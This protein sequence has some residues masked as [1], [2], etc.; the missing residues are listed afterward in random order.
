MQK[1]MIFNVM[2][3]VLAVN[4]C[5]TV[6]AAPQAGPTPPNPMAQVAEAVDRLVDGYGY[7]VFTHDDKKINPFLPNN[8]DISAFASHQELG[9]FLTKEPSANPQLSFKVPKEQVIVSVARGPDFMADSLANM[10]LMNKSK[11]EKI[12]FYAA[13]LPA[14][15]IAS[16]NPCLQQGVVTAGYQE[17][18]PGGDESGC[19]PFIKRE[20]TA[21]YNLNSLLGPTVYKDKEQATMAYDFIQFLTGLNLPYEVLEATEEARKNPNYPK[22]QVALRNY[23]A[24]LGVGTANLYNL[25]AERLPLENYEEKEQAN[26]EKKLV[27]EL[28][29]DRYAATRRL[30]SEEWQRTVQQG[31]SVTLMREQ[32]YLLAEMRY[33]MYKTR[34]EMQRMIATLSAM[35]IQQANA[36]QRVALDRAKEAVSGGITPE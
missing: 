26:K 3:A 18:K 17:G 10:L 1:T 2:M 21:R 28:E 4:A 15:V 7:K 25:M 12:V 31:T 36:T 34:M 20:A 24:N 23:A 8:G 33:E 6:Y 22:Y 30:T 27:S 19:P 9:H 35:E 5:Q 13:G 32:L 11:S 29:L 14:P 16:N